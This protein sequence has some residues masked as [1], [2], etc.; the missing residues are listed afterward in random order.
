[1][2]HLRVFGSQDYAQIDDAKRGNLESKRFCCM[3]LDYAEN[4]KRY[5]FLDLDDAKVKTSR[6]EKLDECEVG[7]INDTQS[8]QLG[9]VIQITTER[10]DGTVP[11]PEKRQPIVDEPMEPAE[12]PISD[13]KIEDVE[14]KEE[15][16]QP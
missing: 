4:V 6:S 5:R 12:K 10:D 16:L 2:E 11:I 8:S 13:V 9:T 14:P 1:M 7:G 15:S 3:F